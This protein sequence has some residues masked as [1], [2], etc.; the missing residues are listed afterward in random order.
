MFAVRWKEQFGIATRSVQRP[1]APPAKRRSPGEKFLEKYHVEHKRME[2]VTPDR[3]ELKFHPGH[4]AGASIERQERV[5]SGGMPARAQGTRPAPSPRCRKGSEG[6][7]GMPFSHLTEAI[8]AQGIKQ[9]TGRFAVSL[10]AE[11]PPSPGASIA[12]NPSSDST[13]YRLGWRNP[14]GG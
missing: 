1:R 14:A 4:L 2:G 9:H 7:D 8:N 11:V 13:R 3:R 6:V 5:P 10:P 12:T